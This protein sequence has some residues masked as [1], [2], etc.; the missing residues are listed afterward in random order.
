M[1]ADEHPTRVLRHPPRLSPLELATVAGG[2]ALD[3]DA[4]G[5]TPIGVVRVEVDGRLEAMTEAV[6]VGGIFE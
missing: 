4:A 1:I 2:H 3:V 6:D 5:E